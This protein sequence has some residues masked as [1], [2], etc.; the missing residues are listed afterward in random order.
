MVTLRRRLRR[1]VLYYLSNDTSES[2][3][4]IDRFSRRSIMLNSVLLTAAMATMVYKLAEWVIFGAPTNLVIAVS[5]IT[6]LLAVHVY[7]RFTKNIN[8]TANLVTLS[9]GIAQLSAH[10]TLDRI[11]ARADQALYQAKANGRNRIEVEPESL[12]DE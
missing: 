8:I 4:T 12:S 2:D 9:I 3:Q 1:Q 5:N 10:D 11:M 7:F 6:I